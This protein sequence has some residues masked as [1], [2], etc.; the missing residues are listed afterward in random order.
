M[1]IKQCKVC[2]EAWPLKNSSKKL[3]DENYKC[4]RCTRDKGSPKKFS[5]ENRMIPSVVP[6][7]LQNLTQC[8]EMLISRALPIM[9]VYTKPGGGYFGYKGHV[10]TLPHNVQ[11]IASTLPNL[12]KT[13]HKIQ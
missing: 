7:E 13:Y 10:I 5:R 1:T 8:E 6:P 3:N 4:T 12:T 11:Y 9:S 2:F